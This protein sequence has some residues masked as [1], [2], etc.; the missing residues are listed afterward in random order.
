M[1][2]KNK[3][4][5][6]SGFTLIEL[7]AVIVILAVIALIAAPIVL[8][9]INDSKESAKLRSAENYLSAVNLSI[10]SENLNKGGGFYP[11][12]CD[13]NSSGNLL[14]DGSNDEIIIQVDGEKPTSGKIIFQ[15]SK[16]DTANLIYDDVGVLTG[17]DGKLVYD[18]T[19]LNDVIEVGG[20]KYT[21]DELATAISNS[22]ASAPLKLLSDTTVS[23]QYIINSNKEMFLDLN[24][25]KITV[26]NSGAIILK[27]TNSSLT[28]TNGNIESFGNSS[29][30]IIGEDNEDVS[31]V[32]KR[33]LIIKENVTITA[34]TYGIAGFGKSQI[35]FYGKLTLTGNGFGI[36]GNGD[37]NNENTIFNIYP[38]SKIV[39]EN[40]FALYLPQTGV[41]TI[42][43]GELIGKTT[44][45]IKSGTLNITGGTF[46]ST[47]SKQTPVAKQN[48]M[49]HTGDIILMEEHEKYDGGMNIKITGGTFTSQ[50]GYIIQENNT[51]GRTTNVSGL[52]SNKILVFFY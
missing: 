16:I 3:K 4:G 52:Y 35:D 29:A 49:N 9:I 14:C 8:N 46:K 44:I 26:M 37:F 25:K 22:S 17:E 34:A 50:N 40:G 42:S 43:G 48:G 32:I 41:T 15:D 11:K 20:V 18:E 2:N 5:I 28:V 39:A 10:M 38:G 36:S 45:G 27:G 6:S 12:T 13:I 31:G 7:L 51:T 19:V 1:K 21:I 47:G 23:S 33:Q 24:G 30:F